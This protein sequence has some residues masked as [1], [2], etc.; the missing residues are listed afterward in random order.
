V[1][2]AKCAGNYAASLLPAQ[3]AIEDGFDQVMW[4]DAKEFKYIQEVGTM[5]LFFVIDGVVVTPK[6]D[7]AILK[8]ITRD[9]IITFLKDKGYTV[10][11]R[12]LSIDEVVEAYKAGKLD[13]AFGSGTAAV[14]QNIKSITYQDITMEIK[15]P[16]NM[17]VANLARE[18]I[19]GIRAGT[20]AD[21]F[22]W[23]HPIEVG[24]L[25]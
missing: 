23:V 10:E 8:G 4:L 3:K 6:T 22:N 2:E 11:E 7:G 25:A 20:I 15:D 24:V 12:L 9:S 18:Q 16:A 14:V 1:G 21:K 5:N 19:K 17:E 13:E